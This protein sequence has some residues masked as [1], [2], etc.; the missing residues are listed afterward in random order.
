MTTDAYRYECKNCKIVFFREK[1]NINERCRECNGFAHLDWN[2]FGPAQVENI[3]HSLD[4][5]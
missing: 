4:D 2:F 5:R 3:K 1:P